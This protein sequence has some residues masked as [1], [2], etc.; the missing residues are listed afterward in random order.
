MPFSVHFNSF[1]ALGELCCNLSVVIIL[2]ILFL[3]L[4]FATG[5]QYDKN[6]DYTQWW[7][8]AS[9]AAFNSRTKCFVDQ[10]NAYKL[11][12]IPVILLTDHH[13]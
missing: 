12:G 7:T 6:G 1:S 8:N 10:Y 5:Q 9:I 11:E 2:Y 3:M 13:M 4:I